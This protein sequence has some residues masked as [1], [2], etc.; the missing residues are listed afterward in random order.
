[1]S[2]RNTFTMRQFLVRFRSRAPVT[3]FTDNGAQVGTL[4]R[5]G[6][7]SLRSEEGGTVFEN[8]WL[9]ASGW[10]IEP[11]CSV[12]YLVN[13]ISAGDRRGLGVWDGRADFSPV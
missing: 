12:Y 7:V 1:V 11:S 5:R 2:E 4:V 13:A 9:V 6:L 10:W 3:Q 8:Q